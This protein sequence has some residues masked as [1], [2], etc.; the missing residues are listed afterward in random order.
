MKLLTVHDK[1]M[2]ELQGGQKVRVLL[3]Q[4]LFG[5]PAALLLDEP[6]NHLDLDSINALNVALQKY[7]GTVLLVTHD[8][9]LLEE[10]GTRVWSFEDG[11]VVDFK[12]T[13][14][15]FSAKLALA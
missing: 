6:T 11:R 12:G 4:A 8:Q 13:Y 15:E 14:E 3:A 5:H 9:D 1:M 7:E 2:A 10:V